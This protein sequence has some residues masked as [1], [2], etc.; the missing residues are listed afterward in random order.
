MPSCVS[1]GVAGSVAYSSPVP[2]R[3]TA[4]CSSLPAVSWAL[5]M[6]LVSCFDELPNCASYLFPIIARL[7][8]R[9]VVLVSEGVS[10]F[11]SRRASRWSRL[12]PGV[13]FLCFFSSRSP[14]VCGCLICPRA[15]LVPSSRC[16]VS[17]CVSCGSPGSSCA[18][19]ISS[20]MA[21]SPRPIVSSGGRG[22][23]F[24]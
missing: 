2:S 8:L 20:L 9:L 1:S 22:G 23:A 21:F 4:P 5:L 19:L 10:L 13:F 3:L 15:R 6:S 24:R 16:P 7:V 11:S 17:S 18:C 14:V 12:A